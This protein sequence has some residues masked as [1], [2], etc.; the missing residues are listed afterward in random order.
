MDSLGRATCQAKIRLG[1]IG[2]TSRGH[3]VGPLKNIVDVLLRVRAGAFSVEAGNVRHTH[4]R[5][6]WQDVKLPDGKTLIPGVVSHATNVVE[7]PELVADRI[8]A[9]RSDQAASHHGSAAGGASASRNR[10]F[11]SAFPQRRIT[12]KRQISCRTCADRIEQA[13]AKE[14][15]DEQPDRNSVDHLTPRLWS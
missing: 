6:V 12:A 11:E 4:E 15:G 9:H 1:L 8:A 5:K 14:C 10:R 7:H 3:L 13:G 2:A